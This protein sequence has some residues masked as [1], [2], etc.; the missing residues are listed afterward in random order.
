MNW[1]PHIT[2]DGST[3]F[4]LWAPDR[5]AVDL[6]LADGTVL[7]MDRDKGGWFE[8]AADAPPGARYRFRISDDLAV[9]DPA[10][11]LQSGGVPIR[12]VAW[13]TDGQAPIAWNSSRLA[14]P[15]LGRGG[16][17]LGVACADV[18]GGFAAVTGG[19]LRVLARSWRHQLSQLHAVSDLQRRA[20]LGAID[21]VRAPMR[22][23]ESYRPRPERA[24]RRL[25]TTAAAMG[26]A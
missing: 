25:M 5:D 2:A 22:V 11:R 13:Y 14:R 19:T 20:Q 23:A 1:G 16:V 12:L 4:R 24:T 21:S 10:S 9:P 8:V 6:E 7:P 18:L 3:R 17:F 15:A 26:W